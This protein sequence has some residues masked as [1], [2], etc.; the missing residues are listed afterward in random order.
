[1]ASAPMLYEDIFGLEMDQDRGAKTSQNP[2]TGKQIARLRKQCALSAPEFAQILGVSAASVCR[3][4]KTPGKL[5]LHT[6]T[7]GAL[8]RVDAEVNGQ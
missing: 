6:R 4:E 3:W 2:P 5:S 1:M 8:R 7:L